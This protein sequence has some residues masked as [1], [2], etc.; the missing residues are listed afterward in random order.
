MNLRTYQAQSMHEA[1]SLV[2]RDLGRDAVILHTR[3]YKK[4]GLLGFGGKTMIEVT[5]AVGVN[6]L[7]ASRRPAVARVDGEPSRAA[8]G[9][10]AATRSESA[11]ASQP[12][13][14]MRSKAA[15]LAAYAA[16]ARKTANPSDDSAVGAS[17]TPPA[18]SQPHRAQGTPGRTAPA[19]RHGGR[20]RQGEPQ[21]PWAGPAR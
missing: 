21:G 11:R 7:P 8:V 1:L 17:L 4:G 14:A 13:T 9:S 5:A 15:V 6:V 19:A 20:T 16:A 10:A 2:K 18:G 12:Q 3:A